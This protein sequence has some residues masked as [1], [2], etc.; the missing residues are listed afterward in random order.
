[1]LNNANE[2]INLK[3]EKMN[4]EN[5]NRKESSILFLCIILFL[6]LVANV[7]VVLTSRSK[8]NVAMFDYSVP[9][10][11]FTGV[12]SLLAN[13]CLIL[14][15][16]FYKKPGYILALALLLLQ[17]PMLIR[18]IIVMKS[19]SN[20]PGLFNDAFAILTISLIY[21][22]NKKINEYRVAE[23]ETLKS[24]QNVSRRL[25]EQTA[26]ALVN[27][28]DSKDT[29]SHGHSIR[30]AEYSK[31]IAEAMGKSEETCMKVYYAALLHDVGKIG[32]PVSI[33][34]KKGT[35]TDEE[36][37]VIKQH[38]VIGN[39]ILSSISEY[40]YLSIG[41]HFHHERYD[42]KGYP[43]RLKGEDIPEIARI[44]AVADAY[45]AMSSNRSY[46]A[47]I[48]QQ[49]IREEFVK[50]TGTQFD[51]EISRIMQHL[52]DL[53][54]EYQMK[55]KDTISEFAGKEELKCDE[56]R[57]EVSEG[58]IVTSNITNI[59]M[60]AESKGKS[61]SK[62]KGPSLILFDSLD[63]HVHS[64]EK[65]AEEL[66]YCEYCE[67]WFDGKSNDKE[68][69][70]IKTEIVR[71]NPDKH[72]SK[73]E[74][75]ISE[76]DIEAVKYKDHILIRIDDGNK[77]IE[78]T[79]ALMDNSR[80]A[81]LAI[82]G[83]NC[84]ISDVSISKKEETIDKNYIT[85]IADEISYI[86]V[87]EGDLPN[88]QID[89]YRTDASKG[90]PIKDNLK[91]KFHTMSL[92]TARLVWHCAYF[93]IYHSEDGKLNGN[94]YRE[95]ALIR[96]DGENWETVRAAENIMNVKKQDDFKGW[97]DWKEKNK[98][99]YDC[100]VSFERKA[101]IITTTTENCGISIKN[102]TKVLDGVDNI[103]VALTGDQCAL[104]NIIIND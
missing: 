19:V 70:N 14:I 73:E 11:S 87:P 84:L 27:A 3:N 104:T 40:P 33:I 72:K 18:N 85:R 5:L 6:Y 67:L 44:I 90:I 47:A 51:P 65:M 13:T 23:L 12:F 68:I 102:V 21:Q 35:L 7:I 8:G 16:I 52:I 100:E 92:P 99:G 34:N 43:D 31:K 2:N 93:I 82:T 63:G 30:V 50:G 66:N 103:Y 71:N 54:S 86:D 77:K 25:F 10:Q 36:Y 28:I 59:H 53:D 62:S 4:N 69:R 46:R 32:V 38:P 60:K 101:N 45:D 17:F 56:Y 79:I 24:K 48:P 95:Y 39:Q 26:N 96:L 74:K 94:D 81:Y 49:L 42:G 58:I 61:S 76:Y 64:D 41:A 75:N 20:I 57:S 1:M 9:V 91:I 88:V 55:E 22:R 83:E 89:G 29:Y 97:D 80:F 98:Q 78:T 15:V 37:E